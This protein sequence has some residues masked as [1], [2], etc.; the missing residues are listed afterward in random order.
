MYSLFSICLFHK[1]EGFLFKDL[2]NFVDDDSKA[3]GKI[4]VILGSN[5]LGLLAVLILIGLLSS[6][7]FWLCPM[8][9]R[10]SKYFEIIG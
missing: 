9:L 10:I 1:D 8:N 2:S 4:I 7:L 6:L 3:R 5:L